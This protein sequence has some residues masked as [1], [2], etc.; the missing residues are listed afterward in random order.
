M[1][2]PESVDTNTAHN[3]VL[4]PSARVEESAVAV[5]GIDFDEYK[6]RDV[7][8][9]E[10]LAD[11]AF[12]GFQASAVA[13]AVRIINGMVRR[14]VAAEMT[15]MGSDSF[16]NRSAGKTMTRDEVPPSSSA[17]HPISYHQAFER[18]S[19]GSYSTN[20]SQRS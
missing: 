19:D 11:M 4:Q 18:P 8:V 6:D 2:Q 3:A 16:A 10:L 17:S 12:A 9:A 20:V 15:S 13:E 7:T 14:V 1:P 5:R